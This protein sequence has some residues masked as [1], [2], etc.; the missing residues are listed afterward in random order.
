MLWMIR[1]SYNVDVFISKSCQQTLSSVFTEDSLKEIPVLEDFF[2]NPTD[3]DFEY[4]PGKFE[5][6]AKRKEFRVGKT[7]W[8]WPRTEILKPIMKSKGIAVSGD[9]YSSRFRGYK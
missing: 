7:L 4:F 8:L 3:I 9:D 6:I 5:D 2:C 1:R